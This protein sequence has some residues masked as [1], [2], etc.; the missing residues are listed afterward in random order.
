MNNNRGIKTHQKDFKRSFILTKKQKE[1]LQRNQRKKDQVELQELEKKVKQ[2]QIATF[3]KTIPIIISSTILKSIIKNVEVLTK[4]EPKEEEKNKNL[5]EKITIKKWDNNLLEEKKKKEVPKENK[6]GNDKKEQPI[7]SP[8]IKIVPI[9]ELP[10]K[11][12][13]KESKTENEKGKEKQEVEEL[14]E[15]EKLKNKKLI[16]NY[17]EKLKEERTELK[18]LAASFPENAVGDFHYE[19]AEAIYQKLNLILQKLEDLERKIKID[20]KKYDDAYVNHLIDLYTE[21]FKKG[22]IA[23]DLKDSELY[24]S[25][26]K[27]LDELEKEKLKIKNTLKEISK[28][29]QEE[30]KKEKEEPKKEE[31]RKLEIVEEKKDSFDYSKQE[32]EYNDFQ[33]EQQKNLI[34]K[35]EKFQKAKTE[36]ERM[37]TQVEA[38][39]RECHSLKRMITKR[40]LMKPTIRNAKIISVAVLTSVFF[41]KLILK[42]KAFRKPRKILKRKEYQRNIET[43][44][45]DITAAS[46]L[47]NQSFGQIESLIAQIKRNLSIYPSTEYESLLME[48]ESIKRILEERKYE[49]EQIKNNQTKYQKE[50]SKVYRK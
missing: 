9:P 21:G 34:Q 46:N 47:I 18:T 4:Q 40:S 33:E 5:E 12:R 50:E 13:K 32:K 43:N 8:E 19:K 24:I 3:F 17:E 36:Y 39:K 45:I 25:I 35:E 10:K 41:M 14:K 15:L 30:P 23:E 38:L 6:E 1:K 37:K 49:I 29:K 44:V 26:S 27:K 16:K 22:K 48:L 31:E 42:N 28:N 2:I 7:S 20:D 11:E